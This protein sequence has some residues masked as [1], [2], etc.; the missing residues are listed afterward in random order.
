MKL[1][2]KN[3]NPTPLECCPHCH[4]EGKIEETGRNYDLAAKMTLTRYQCK[5][6]GFWIVGM[7]AMTAKEYE[8]EQA[9]EKAR[10]DEEARIERERE[11]KRMQEQAA[12]ASVIQGI[13]RHRLITVA[14]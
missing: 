7:S 1:K 13:K 14:K 4:T 8:A 9:K 6:C 3:A 12:T 10:L 2:K 11:A 5:A